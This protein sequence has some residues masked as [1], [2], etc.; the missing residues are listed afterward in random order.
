MTNGP[1]DYFFFSCTANH[2]ARARCVA[3]WMRRPDALEVKEREAALPRARDVGRACQF[4]LL[5]AGCFLFARGDS[6]NSRSCGRWVSGCPCRCSRRLQ[7]AQRGRQVF[8]DVA[9][10][11]L[12]VGS[13]AQRG[14]GSRCLTVP[15]V[16]VCTQCCQCPG[17]LG[18]LWS[19][20]RTG[21][22]G[23]VL[24]IANVVLCRESR[25]DAVCTAEE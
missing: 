20:V 10:S 8:G 6:P 15:A 16:R 25:V 18:I 2:E 12:S 11:Q 4:R 22:G 24:R 21:E 14:K 1:A 9:G 7:L 5:E 19:S 3:L 17:P 23:G 13:M